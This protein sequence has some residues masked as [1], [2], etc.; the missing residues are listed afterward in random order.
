MAMVVASPAAP[1]AARARPASHARSTARS[2]PWCGSPTTGEHS[3]PRADVQGLRPIDG[4]RVAGEVPQ[5]V[6]HRI[7]GAARPR[8]FRA[9]AAKTHKPPSDSNAGPRP[10]E[11]TPCGRSA[12]KAFN[13]P[14]SIRLI[15]SQREIGRVS[16]RS[17]GERQRSDGS[18]R[19]TLPPAQSRQAADWSCASASWRAR[20]GAA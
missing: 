7:A 4:D 3:S 10:R 5:G 6:D 2:H 1:R 16:R 14:G 19:Q 11:Q 8:R 20:D 12:D 13:S 9:I 15:P 17:R 18:G